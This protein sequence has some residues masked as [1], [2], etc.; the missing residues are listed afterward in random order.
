METRDSE[1]PPEFALLLDNN[2]VSFRNCKGER[3]APSCGR[4]RTG[5]LASYSCFGAGKMG[6]EK[7]EGLTPLLNT[8]FTGV[9]SLT[10]HIQLRRLLFG[11][12]PS[13]LFFPH[14]AKVAPDH[15]DTA[16]PDYLLDAETVQQFKHGLDF[17]LVAGDFDG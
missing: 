3:P 16:R 2:I 1:T 15:G 10:A 14:G 12:A 17:I 5:S 8:S 4:F 6:E 13:G 11:A 7:E 9:R